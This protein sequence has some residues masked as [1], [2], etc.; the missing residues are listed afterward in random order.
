V[1]PSSEVEIASASALGRDQ[2]SRSGIWEALQAPPTLHAS[3]PSSQDVQYGH[4]TG[5]PR[6]DQ[7][8]LRAT[9]Q[10][11]VNGPTVPSQAAEAGAEGTGTSQGRGAKLSAGSGGGG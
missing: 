6:T 3:K 1:R 7:A 11:P 5:N 8:E 9:L 2:L 4:L 10:D